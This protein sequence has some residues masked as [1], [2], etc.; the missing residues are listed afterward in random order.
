MPPMMT[1]FIPTKFKSLDENLVVAADNNNIRLVKKSIKKGANLNKNKAGGMALMMACQKGYVSVV[2]VLINAGVSVN[3][4]VNNDDE[5]PLLLACQFGH[6]NVVAS[7]LKAGAIPTADDCLC[8]CMACKFGHFDIVKLIMDFNPECFEIVSFDYLNELAK[9]VANVNDV[10]EAIHNMKEEY[11][12][13]FVENCNIKK[14][15]IVKAIN[16]FNII[17]KDKDVIETLNNL[18]IK[19]V[20]ETKLKLKRIFF[21]RCI[22]YA[23]SS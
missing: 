23:Q 6:T 18:N 22:F 15:D 2:D 7:L 10:V 4:S 21:P 17:K 1:T 14:E 5:F 16:N 3:I 12:N 20:S 8:L 19:N 13:E 9:N 11:I